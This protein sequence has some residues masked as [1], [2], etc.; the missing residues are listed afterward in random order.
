MSNL[1][2]RLG[3][4]SEKMYGPQQTENLKKSASEIFNDPN[5]KN[6]KTPN[7]IENLTNL[8]AG[9]NKLNKRKSEIKQGLTAHLPKNL[10]LKKIKNMDQ[11]K[12]VNLLESKGIDTKQIDNFKKYQDVKKLKK[13]FKKEVLNIV[14]ANTQPEYAVEISQ[15]IH[16]LGNGNPAK[17]LFI[18]GIFLFGIVFIMADLISFNHIASNIVSYF[19]LNLAFLTTLPK[20]IISVIGLFPGDYTSMTKLNELIYFIST[21]IISFFL[22][23]KLYKLYITQKCAEEKLECNYNEEVVGQPFN[24]AFITTTITYALMIIIKF[25]V[26]FVE[27]VTTPYSPPNK[28]ASAFLRLYDYSELFKYGFI[29]NFIGTIIHTIVL[30]SIKS[31]MSVQPV[32]Y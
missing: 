27:K 1:P 3:K 7:N 30:Y 31:K 11:S 2:N 5:I 10:D 9:L 8:K 17:V 4:I 15:L 26:K 25:L 12:A 23:Y 29:Y 16:S 21:Y 28:G 24:F 18:M 22:N 32:S 20:I 6:I 19:I 14:N 13:V